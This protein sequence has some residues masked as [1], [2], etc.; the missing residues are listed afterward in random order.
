MPEWPRDLTTVL[1]AAY[2][3]YQRGAIDYVP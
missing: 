2:D 3:A 1:A